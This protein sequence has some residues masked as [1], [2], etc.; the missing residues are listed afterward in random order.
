MSCLLEYLLMMAVL[1]VCDC[2]ITARLGSLNWKGSHYCAI[3][4]I[5]AEQ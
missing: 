5:T 2:G 3:A 4:Q 1:N